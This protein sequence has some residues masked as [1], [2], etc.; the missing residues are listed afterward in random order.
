LSEVKKILNEIEAGLQSGKSRQQL[1]QELKATATPDRQY[2]DFQALISNISDPESRKL[3]AGKLG[4]LLTLGLLFMLL[5]SITYIFSITRPEMTFAMWVVWQPLL[6]LYVAWCL[7]IIR[8]GQ[9]QGFHSILILGFLYL[10]QTIKTLLSE[11]GITFWIEFTFFS[12]ALS[13]V[14][15]SIYIRGRLFPWLSWL[16][17]VREKH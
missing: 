4:L 9:F 14:G 3:H 1:L 5:N 2:E 16:G 7:S 11:T 8:K 17:K 12:L 13:I 6:I 10:P 15:L